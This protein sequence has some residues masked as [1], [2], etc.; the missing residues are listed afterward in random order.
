MQFTQTILAISRTLHMKC[1]LNLIRIRHSTGLVR[2]KIEISWILKDQHVPAYRLALRMTTRT[3]S[4]SRSVATLSKPLKRKR[5]PFCTLHLQVAGY[6][7]QPFELSRYQS[8]FTRLFF[9]CLR[10]LKNRTDAPD[11]RYQRFSI[12]SYVTFIFYIYV[13]SFRFLKKM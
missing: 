12:S 2:K 6:A 11:R 1:T 7:R 8:R 5:R 13:F 3:S 4:L 9:H 10:S